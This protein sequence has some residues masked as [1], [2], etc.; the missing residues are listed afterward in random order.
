[1]C[2][3]CWKAQGNS[4]MATVKKL[5]KVRWYIKDTT[6]P[7]GRREVRAGTPGAVK[8]KV[9]ESVYFIVFKEG[10]KTKRESTGLTDKRAAQAYLAKWIT[11]REHGRVGLIDPHKE[12]L[13]R[14]IR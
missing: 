3:D 13:D 2:L 1:M 6:H 8:V 7:K 11:A 5:S 9:T 4:T 14:P 12:H 10:G